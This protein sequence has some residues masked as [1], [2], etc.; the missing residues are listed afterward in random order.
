MNVEQMLAL[1]AVKLED[2]QKKFNQAHA[3][4][5]EAV[6]ANDYALFAMDAF[7]RDLTK[8]RML[9]AELLREIML[10]E[11]AALPS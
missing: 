4:H 3:D 10:R 2:A 1:N 11:E 8:Y 6:A 7:K 5:L 9:E